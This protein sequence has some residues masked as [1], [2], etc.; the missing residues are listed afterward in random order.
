MTDLSQCRTDIETAQAD[1]AAAQRRY[2]RA[3]ARR[4]TR[5]MLRTR[6]LLEEAT[7]RALSLEVRARCQNSSN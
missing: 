6:V 2:D 1:R 7:N 3:K 5:A 4:N